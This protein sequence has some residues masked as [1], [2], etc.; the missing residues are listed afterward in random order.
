MQF[1]PHSE[2]NPSWLQKPESYT[3][4]I[5]ICSEIHTNNIN[6]MRR[7]TPNFLMVR[8]AVHTINI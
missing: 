6:T 8:L 1:E 5:A 4:N 2:Q 7:Q 3:Q